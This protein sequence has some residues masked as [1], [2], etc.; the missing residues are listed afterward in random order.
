MSRFPLPPSPFSALCENI[1]YLRQNFGTAD[2]VV[3]E[4][5]D[6]RGCRL[7]VLCGFITLL[8]VSM[9]TPRIGRWGYSALPNRLV[10]PSST[11]GLRYK[12]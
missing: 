9:E 7:L 10:Y 8:S 5:E 12:A 2:G 4:M 3:R 6:V 11:L 1:H